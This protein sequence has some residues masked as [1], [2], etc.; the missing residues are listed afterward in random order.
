VT[1]LLDEGFFS[2]RVTPD[3]IDRL[4]SEGWRHFGPMFYRYARANHGGRIMDVRPLRITLEQFVPTK[5]QR[6]VL[7]KNEGLGVRVRPTMIDD[8]RR[9][10][11]HAH[12]RRFVENIPDALE[13]FL[14]PDPARG[15]CLNLEIGVYAGARLL[16][17]SYLDIGRT[18]VSSVYGF[19]DPRESRRSLGILTML[20][21]I[22]WAQARGCRYYYPGYAYAQPSHYDYKKQFV[23]L[24]W[25]DW[26]KWTTPVQS[27]EV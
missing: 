21:E 6:R 26:R 10:L 13:D 5:S 11:F 3:E 27:L 24:E 19:F 14:G 15:P 12:R 17:A 23:G 7:R 25:Y 2:W 8:T 1:P 20:H 9:A 16:A 4:W 22:A 18:A